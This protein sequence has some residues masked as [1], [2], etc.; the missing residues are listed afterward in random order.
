MRC[1]P[2]LLALATLLLPRS[3]AYT[4]DNCNNAFFD[5]VLP[6]NA[7]TLLTSQVPANGSFGQA[8]DIAYPTN[9]TNLPALCAVIIN[10]T[11]SATSSYTFGLF[12]PNEWNDR[13]IA[14]GNGGFSGGINWYS[15]GSVVPYGFA[16]I[17]TNT[18][19]NSTG[20][21][22]DWALN[23][24]E[25]KTDWGYR[26]LHGS[27]LLGKQVTNAYYSSSL[28]YSYYA[29]CSTGGKQGM[30]EV[31]MFPEDFDGVLV[32]AP[33]WW[34]THQQL[35]Q[36]TVGITN[37]PENSSHFIPY[38]MFQLMSD[39]VVRQCDASDGIVDGI[40]MD[41]KKCNFIPQTLLCQPGQNTSTCLTP[42]QI[43]TWNTL[44][45]P[46]A[47]IHNTWI[48]PNF[49]LGSEAQM[50]SS[51]GNIGTNAPSLYGTQ[52]V[53]N[54]VLDDPNWDWTTYNYSVVQIADALNPGGTNA[55][56][57]DISPFHAR[58]GK[59]LHYHGLAD[60]LIPTGASE[61]LYNNY[62]YNMTEKNIALDD[63]YRFF[64]IPG[65]QHCQNSVG[66]APW[67][68]GGAQTLANV[69]GVP[70]FED[71]E[72]DALLALMDWVEKGNAPDYIITTKWQNDDPKQAV[73][74]QRPVCKYPGEATYNGY[75]SINA[76]ESWSCVSS[77]P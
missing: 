22:M 60:G 67:Y 48:Y 4:L 17:S 65:M 47:D 53:A 37:L 75:G 5:S 7:S 36:L 2:P 25:A 50:S 19:H 63:W 57:F 13:F 43:E 3:Y 6:T 28:S 58:G 20:Q 1:W 64:L 76:S 46:I 9:A 44:H 18:G 71:K 39:E 15:M 41:P 72:H 70:G 29:G 26:A 73:V 45:R 66:D 77:I 8:A 34:S 12:L 52:Y 14:V 16:T 74:R 27:V 31:Q 68:L 11:S 35:W 69:T 56:N 10:V 61:L 23:N 38:D 24:P 62:L 51:F 54:Y 32:G 49:G 30:Q 33:A 55:V 21:N 40:I 42:P 59:L